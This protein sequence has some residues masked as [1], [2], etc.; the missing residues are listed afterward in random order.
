MRRAICRYSACCSSPSQFLRRITILRPLASQKKSVF[1]IVGTLIGESPGGTAG[2][3]EVTSLSSLQ[4]LRA[5]S[6][7]KRLSVDLSKTVIEISR[8]KV[9]SELRQAVKGFRAGKTDAFIEK[10]K[11][12]G[13]VH[14]HPQP[15]ERISAVAKEYASTQERTVVLSE[16]QSDRAAITAQ[17]RAELQ[18]AGR[19]AQ[20]QGDHSVLRQ[21]H[22]GRMAGQRITNPAT[23]SSMA[24]AARS[25]DSCLRPRPP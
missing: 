25:T 6:L 21:Q 18:Q 20:D 16:K 23:L 3:F 14:Q 13:K 17:I 15:A 4:P 22:S 11:D 7:A 2:S 8:A 19:L 5:G 10:L 12:Q 24:R 9:K 1:M